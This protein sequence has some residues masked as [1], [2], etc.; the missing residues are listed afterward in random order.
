MGVLDKFFSS[1]GEGLLKGVGDAVSEVAGKFKADP[2]MT[3]ELNE[4]LQELIINDRQATQK[5][6][7]AQYEAQLADIQNARDMQVKVN[8]APTAS[9]LTK[10]INPMLALFVAMI[11]GA[12]TV[13][14]VLRMLNFIAANPNVN[15]T[16]VL[17]VYSAI[18]G[19]MGILM[20]FYFGSSDSSKSKDE[21]IASIAKAP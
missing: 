18:S 13:Y 14:L 17:G 10:N 3:A 5:L 15:M 9:W 1:T 6:V 12:M 2:T 11:W 21:T 8:Q 4:K 19:T 20:N 16:A 7:E